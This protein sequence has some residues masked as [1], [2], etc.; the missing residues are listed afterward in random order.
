MALSLLSLN[1]W[2]GRLHE[3]LLP[4][5]ANAGADIVCLQE[6]IRS[7]DGPSRTCEYRDGPLRL[8][9]RSDL[10]GDIAAAL[11]MHDRGYFPTSTGTLYDGD[12][13]I[14]AQF[15][16]ATFMAKRLP[17]VAQGMEFVHGDYCPHG[18]GDHPRPR[19]AHCIRI[20]DRSGRAFTI[21]HMH[22]LR[23]VDGKDDTP[24]RIAQAEA[25]AALVSRVRRPG[26][27]VIACGDFNVLPGSATFDILGRIGLTDLVTANGHCD[28]RTSWYKKEQRFAD[29]LLV[30]P[31][32][33]VLRFEVVAQPEVSD[34]RPLLLHFA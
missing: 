20:F 5:L 3:R 27:G 26:D 10:F 19:N 12:A 6:V 1:A 30:S 18:W 24:D 7:L 23:T 11:P 15:G 34:H 2:G 28:T 14:A 8:P 13:P 22:G 29:Y 17:V 25:F 31:E 33:D 21:A 16:L 32:V 4:Y 9:Q